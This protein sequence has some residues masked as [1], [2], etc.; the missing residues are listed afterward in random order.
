MNKYNITEINFRYVIQHYGDILLLLLLNIVIPIK[1]LYY[2]LVYLFYL[3]NGRNTIKRFIYLNLILSEIGYVYYFYTLLI[4]GVN[5]LYLHEYLS[6]VN[7]TSKF[8]MLSG[9]IDGLLKDNKCYFEKRG[10][11]IL[12]L[13]VQLTHIINKIMFMLC[14]CLYLLK[15]VEDIV[16]VDV[17]KS[18]KFSNSIDKLMSIENNFGLG[19]TDTLKELNVQ[20]MLNETNQFFN[21][22]KKIS[23]GGSAN[24]NF[25]VVEIDE[26]L[27]ESLDDFM[28]K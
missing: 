17:P 9:N 16:K 6:L 5:V 12:R 1:I 19:I 22:L 13:Y 26:I 7:L 4:L 15:C 10:G 24:N 8:K 3:F 11:L 18:D 23:K 27:N 20:Q 28:K 14:Y 25:N 21:K 2:P